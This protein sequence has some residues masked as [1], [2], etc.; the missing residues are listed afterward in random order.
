MEM[1]A[2]VNDHEQDKILT[3]DKSLLD[4]DHFD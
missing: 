3:V 1:N 4:K 2:N